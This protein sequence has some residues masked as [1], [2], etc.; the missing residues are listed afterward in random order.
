[1]PVSTYPVKIR[2]KVLYNKLY[3]ETREVKDRRSWFLSRKNYA[4]NYPVSVIIDDRTASVC[5]GG[6]VSLYDDVYDWLIENQ[7]SSFCVNEVAMMLGFVD[8]DD[9][10]A[11]RIR[12][13][14]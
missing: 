13:L 6:W 10:L 3:S 8:E 9:A 2:N 4:S 7:C 14:S 11:F 5:P 12:F 1:M